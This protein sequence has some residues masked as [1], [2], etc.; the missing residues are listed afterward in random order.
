MK[1]EDYQNKINHIINHLH[2][3][4]VIM[5][6]IIGEIEKDKDKVE[7]I[8]RTSYLKYL[9]AF[10]PSFVYT[11]IVLSTNSLSFIDNDSIAMAS[12]AFLF[13]FASSLQLMNCI[14][15]MES[16]S[17]QLKVGDVDFDLISL[18]KLSKRIS[19][20]EFEFFITLL[21]NRYFK[22]SIYSNIMS[23]KN[24]KPN[25]K[26]QK[27]IKNEILEIQK[28]E[29]NRIINLNKQLINNE[30][31]KDFILSLKEEQKKVSI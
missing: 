30:K 20:E 9:K 27:A 14:N 8:N 4:P 11:S 12:N 29:K 25:I 16:D 6:Y 13:L 7:V 15:V 26:R 2:H 18:S 17:E 19:P 1:E 5:E 28:E 21:K 3:H 22:K 10:K 31:R 24:N 23:F